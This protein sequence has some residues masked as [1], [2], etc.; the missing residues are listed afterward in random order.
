MTT[1]THS[2]HLYKLLIVF[3]TLTIFAGISVATASS[4]T[5]QSADNVE[6]EQSTTFQNTTFDVTIDGGSSTETVT[7]DLSNAPTSKH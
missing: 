7:L 1:N 2:S 4:I 6:V 5:G 3:T